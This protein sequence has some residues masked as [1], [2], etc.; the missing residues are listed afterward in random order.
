MFAW[1]HSAVVSTCHIFCILINSLF[2]HIKST[3]ITP[4]FHVL[5]TTFTA[6]CNSH[7]CI[8]LHKYCGS[9][10]ETY[11]SNPDSNPGSHPDPTRICKQQFRIH[12]ADLQLPYVRFLQISM[13]ITSDWL[14]NGDV[15]QGFS[16]SV[17]SI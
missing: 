1:N 2:I 12:N 16:D 14:S 9:G 4:M 15:L 10:S 8:I 11:V 17:S 7:I 5:H 13:T 6:C 3:L